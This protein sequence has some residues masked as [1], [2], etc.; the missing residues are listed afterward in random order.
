MADE[1]VAELAVLRGAA[2]QMETLFHDS[3][4]ALADIDR[5]IAQANEGWKAEAVNAFG[6]FNGYLDDR[7]AL[8]RRNL[9]EMAQ[10]LTT[11]ANNLQSQDQE[12]GDALL[13]Q[14]KPEE[15][16]LNLKF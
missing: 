16:S 1:T 15:S 6:R 9:G 12:T 8:L 2:G 5:A 11:T 4:R 7:R 10:L 14:G 3:G 13:D